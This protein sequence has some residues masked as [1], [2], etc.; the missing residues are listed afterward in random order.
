MTFEEANPE[1]M[2]QII[3]S[4]RKPFKV[5]ENDLTII[6]DALYLQEETERLEGDQ[7]DLLTRVCEEIARR[8]N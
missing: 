1:L 5:S 7:Q 6:K 4:Q 8:N 3:E 2:A